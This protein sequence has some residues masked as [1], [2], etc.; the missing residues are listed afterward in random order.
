MHLDG[1]GS[2]SLQPGQDISYSSL[3]EGAGI[4]REISNIKKKILALMYR[5]DY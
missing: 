1:R 2:R 3:D 4:E 5:H